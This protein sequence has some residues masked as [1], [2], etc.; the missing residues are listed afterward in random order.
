MKSSVLMKL[1][2][3]RPPLF[4]AGNPI[5]GHFKLED[6]FNAMSEAP[7]FGIVLN[8]LRPDFEILRYHKQIQSWFLF[9]RYDVALHPC[10]V[11]LTST[12][13]KTLQIE[14]KYL[15]S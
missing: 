2:S 7:Y 14:N 12:G 13:V 1:L 8:F 9:K 6:G 3:A 10:N 11:D 15:I 4:D 5:D